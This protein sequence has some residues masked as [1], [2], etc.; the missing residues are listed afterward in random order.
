MRWSSGGSCAKVSQSFSEMCLSGFDARIDKVFD[1]WEPFDEKCQVVECGL[2]AIFGVRDDLGNRGCRGGAIQADRG[3]DQLV[4]CTSSY[5]CSA[6]GDAC[7]WFAPAP[8][9]PT[10]EPTK[11]LAPTRLWHPRSLQHQPSLLYRLQHLRNL[12]HPLSLWHRPLKKHGQLI[13]VPSSFSA[14]AFATHCYPTL[15]SSIFPNMRSV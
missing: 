11:S 7:Q 14:S 2:T 13:C 15:M 8:A 4:F 9:C 1:R 12:R 10:S 3:L 5:S 6:A